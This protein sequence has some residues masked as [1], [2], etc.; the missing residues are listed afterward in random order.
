MVVPAEVVRLVEMVEFWVAVVVYLEMV[1]S[2]AVVAAHLQET[3]EEVVV[4]VL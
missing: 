4:P 2:P 1:D 3:V